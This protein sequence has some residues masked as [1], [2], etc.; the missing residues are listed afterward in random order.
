MGPSAVAVSVATTDPVASAAF[1][2]MF[3]FVG[4]GDLRMVV[5]DGAAVAVEFVTV[6]KAGVAPADFDRGPRALDLYTN[7]LDGV[8]AEAAAAGW[9]TSGPGTVSI[10]PVTMGQAMVVGPD[11]LPVVLVESTH[12]RASLLDAL[13]DRRV[14]E[15]HSVVWCVPDLDA[16]AARWQ[17]AGWTKGMDLAFAEPAVSDY[18]GLPRSPVPIRMTMLSGPDVEPIRLELL[19]FPDDPGPAYAPDADM[20]GLRGL[21]F[22]VDD[23]RAVADALQLD[24]STGR[25]PGGVRVELRP[26]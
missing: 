23:V 13:P 14:S 3:G 6:T 2:G 15:P 5:P 24:A 11:G 4:D 22:Q 25:T 12:R 10:G 16:E 1:L 18:L 20:A 19:E 9:P 17:A 8:L 21:V 7:D 26:S